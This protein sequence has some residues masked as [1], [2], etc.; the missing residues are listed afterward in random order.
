MVLSFGASFHFLTCSELPYL[1]KHLKK[2]FFFKKPLFFRIFLFYHP[3][4]YSPITAKESFAHM[5]ITGFSFSTSPSSFLCSLP[6]SQHSGFYLQAATE[7]YYMWSNSFLPTTPTPFF[8]LPPLVSLTHCKLWKAS[9]FLTCPG[10]FLCSFDTR[11]KQTFFFFF[12]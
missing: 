5:V 8:R 10:I 6:N 11:T 3:I 1:T 12:P 7:M 2:K 9:S 4:F